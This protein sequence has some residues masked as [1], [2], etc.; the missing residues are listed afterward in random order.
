MPMPGPE[1][2][3][4]YHRYTGR[5]ET[6]PVYGEAWLRWTYETAPGKLFLRLVV[7]H[8]VFS[9]FSG[10]WMDRSV[11]RKRIPGFVDRYGID[12]S[13]FVDRLDAFPNF[14]SFFARRL[15]RENRPVDPEPGH[16]VFPADGRHLGFPDLSVVQS[17]FV[18]GQ[19]FD[20]TALLG[21]AEAARRYAS[22]ALVLS[23][24]C[25]ID[26]H[27]F[28]YPVSGVAGAPRDI[29]G[30]LYSVNPVALRRNL[31]YLWQNRRFV[32]RMQSDLFGEVLLMEIG[33]TCVGS[34]VQTRPAGGPVAKGLEKGYFRFGGSSVLTFFEPGRIELASDLAEH[35]G[36]GKEL[37][38][39]M[40][41][42]MGRSSGMETEAHLRQQA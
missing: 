4:Y 40:G 8:P 28:H 5:M 20:L 34:I 30:S 7:R 23:R 12:A 17:V 9:K 26:Y 13:E 16:A 39:H 41:D 33:A 22:G 31:G 18:K 2:I 37:Y 35:T 25:P 29:R 11:T 27:R 32:T 24:L 19:R 14:N 38:A 3:Q 1:P 42:V 15:R 21:D 6:E 10:W 36:A